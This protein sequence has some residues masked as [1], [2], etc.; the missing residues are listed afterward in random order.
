MG[1]CQLITRCVPCLLLMQGCMYD[2]GSK[3]V[4]LSNNSNTMICW[5]VPMSGECVKVGNIPHRNYSSVLYPGQEAYLPVIEDILWGDPGYEPWYES[6][7]DDSVSVYIY[8]ID[9]NT[10]S[11]WN[12]E[13]HDK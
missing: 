5:M 2:P 1:F 7:V 13:N 11:K 6:F 9:V 12:Q 3:N 10:L 4:C 8:D